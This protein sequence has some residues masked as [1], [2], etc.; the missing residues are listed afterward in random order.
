MNEAKRLENLG[1]LINNMQSLEFTLRGCLFADELAKGASER[2]TNNPTFK[3]GEVLPKNAYTNY[4][5][6]GKLIRK[7]NQLPISKGFEIDE[8]LV[9]IRDVIAHGRVF[10]YDPQGDIQLVKFKEPKGSE[11]EVDFSAWMTEE[12]VGIQNDRFF[13]AMRKA[14]ATNQKQQAAESSGITSV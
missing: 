10:L 7:Y 12:W 5:S 4:D 2:L 13:D 8:T 1:K 11:V 14:S 6:L 9:E 3:K